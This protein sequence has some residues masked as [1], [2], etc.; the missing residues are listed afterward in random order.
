MLEWG[1][2]LLFNVEYIARLV[3]VE[4]PFR[5]ATS[6]FGL[7]DLASVLPMYVALLV[8]GSHVL[9]ITVV[10]PPCEPMGTGSQRRIAI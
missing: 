2:T 5:Y 6:F 8:P 9:I 3:C 10:W 7:V 1:F 4:R